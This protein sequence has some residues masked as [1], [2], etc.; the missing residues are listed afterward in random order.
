ME[1]YNCETLL[2]ILAKRSP[3]SKNVRISKISKFSK[4]KLNTDE[5]KLIYRIKPDGR[6]NHC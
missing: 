1:P 6:A 2:D 5:V 4:N 3:S